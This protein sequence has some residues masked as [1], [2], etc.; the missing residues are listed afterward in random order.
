MAC[1]NS[2][3]DSPGRCAPPPALRGL[4]L[5]LPIGTPRSSRPES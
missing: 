4:V 2:G 1:G 5:G 3:P